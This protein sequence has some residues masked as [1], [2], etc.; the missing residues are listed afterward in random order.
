MYDFEWVP[1][2]LRM[3][4]CGVFDGTRYRY[5]TTVRGF[6]ERELSSANRGRWFFAHAGGLADV[7]F[8]LETLVKE[9]AGKYKVRA[10]FS[11][12][13]AIIIHV[14][15]GKNAW[16]FVDSYWLLREK[17][18]KIAKWIGMEK[19]GP[20]DG[21]SPEKVKEWYASVDFIELVRYNQIDCEILWN[22]IATFQNALLSMGGQLQMTLASSA[23]HLFRRK[24]LTQPI[25]TN[26]Q[27]NDACRGAYF[28]SRVEVFSRYCTESLYYDIN[29]SFPYAMTR[30]VPGNLIGELENLPDKVIHGGIEENYCYISD[31]SI[32]TPDVYL[33]PTPTRVDGRVFFPTGKWRTYLS[34]IDI[35]LLLRE[36]GKIE[37]VHSTYVFEPFHDLANYALDLY[38]KRKESNDDFEK[39]A[40]KLLLNSLYGK[41]AESN[42][43][44]TL[45]I[46][47]SVE[48][49]ERLTRGNLLFPGVWLETILV[50]IP[51]AHVPISTHIT[52]IARRTLFDLLSLT[53]DFHYCDTDG[54][55]TGDTFQ[56]GTE[57]GQLKLEKIVH[58]GRY[59]VPKV[60]RIDGEKLN[61]KGDWEKVTMVKAKGFSLGNNKQVAIARFEELVAGKEIYV[62]R[63][64]RIREMF[65]TGKATP[66]EK[67]I[68]K[69]LR[70][71]MIGKRFMYP[72]GE[73]RPWDFGELRKK[74]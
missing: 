9:F 24:Y 42:S 28:A 15:Q 20:T 33:P 35:E 7:Q 25:T 49:L 61:D 67:I 44:D 71:K 12:S 52:A 45:H 30:P 68:T 54:F 57:L 74:K 17:L 59:I 55:S 51:H 8:V 47:P 41:F 64:T 43:K 6:I 48:V 31:V 16:H 4:C 70:G 27:L 34:N 53:N 21:M 23:M 1:T 46:N 63:M 56:T 62:E 65:R 72:D 14:T 66:S 60:Y 73:T 37:K 38:H 58:E 19:G 22:A 26:K 39:I 10:S 18:S 11:G 5:Y 69:V 40:Y 32:K 13:S 2:T 50:P 3:R 29:S 36:G